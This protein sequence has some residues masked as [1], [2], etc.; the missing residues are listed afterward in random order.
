MLLA[1]VVF[2]WPAVAPP[3]SLSFSSF[4][5]PAAKRSDHSGRNVDHNSTLTLTLVRVRRAV[6]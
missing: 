2:T 4:P 1:V 3:Q 5:L 6:S